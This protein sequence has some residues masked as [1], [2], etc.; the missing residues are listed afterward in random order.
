MVFISSRSRDTILLGVSSCLMS[1]I[2]GSAKSLNI[3][4]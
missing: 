3:V 4:I 2:G 1:F